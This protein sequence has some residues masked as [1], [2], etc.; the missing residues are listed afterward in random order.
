MDFIIAALHYSRFEAQFLCPFLSLFYNKCSDSLA[1]IFRQN[2]D[3]AQHH[4]VIVNSIKATSGYW[5]VIIDNDDILCF[6]R[7][8]LVRSNLFACYQRDARNSRLSGILCF[9][10]IACMRT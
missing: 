6:W 2:D 4:A 9:R 5:Q 3:S 8:M 10:A 7:V 1:T